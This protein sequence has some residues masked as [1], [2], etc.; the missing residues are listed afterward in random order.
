MPHS[1]AIG[2]FWLS[3]ASCLV[4]QL[5]IVRSVLGARHLPNPAADLPRARGS[6][7]LLWAVAPAVALA[8]LLVF[9]WRA[10]QEHDVRPG[11][12]SVTAR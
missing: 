8:A 2:L 10:I 3:V 7:E 5:F 4:A 1:F 11:P 9:T 6:V 12:L